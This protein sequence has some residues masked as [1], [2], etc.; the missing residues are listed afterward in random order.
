MKEHL[1]SPW[2]E[3]SFSVVLRT[4]HLV[5]VTWLGAGVLGAPTSIG[6]AAAWVLATGVLLAAVD[7]RAHRISLRELA[8][9][10]V[11]LKLAASAAMS[12]QPQLAVPLFVAVVVVSSLAAH[13]PK[14]LRHWR[15]GRRHR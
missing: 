7:L 6:L 10:V 13:A 4:S 11:L 1:R 3:R 2:V 9:V 8:G 15:P 14:W 12:W 5:A